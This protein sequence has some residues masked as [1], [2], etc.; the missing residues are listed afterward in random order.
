MIKLNNKLLHILPSTQ[1]SS[2]LLFV[3]DLSKELTEYNHYVIFEKLDPQMDMDT[4]WLLQSVGI[5][6]LFADVLTPE[7]IEK[8]QA[9]GVIIYNLEGHTDLGSV[10]PSIYYSCGVYDEVSKCKMTVAA[11]DYACIY[12]CKGRPLNLNK[13]FVIPP[14]INTRVLRYYNKQDPNFTVGLITSGA[15]DKYPCEFIIELLSKLDKSKDV[16]LGL[17]ILDK[18]KHPGT[19]L[20]IDEYSKTNKL[21]R[22]SHKITAGLYY[23]SHCDVVIYATA[24]NYYEPYSRTVVE[25]M[26]FG[27]PVIC[28]N[29]GCF[30][31][32]FEH[33]NNILLFNMVDEAVEYINK[34]KDKTLRSSIGLNGQL[35]S[36][37][38]DI[39]LH[40]GKMK[41]A[42]RMIGV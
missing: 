42:L 31:T 40:S 23:I 5:N 27:R 8:E 32:L 38:E 13:E 3:I 20:A 22:C 33:N 15:R 17:T 19:Q 1:I 39:S 36:S 35:R 18:Y 37:W 2:D 34:L 4:V 25:A 26:A 14:A 28:E 12:D 16:I 24:N 29:R 41:K 11:S 21:I 10:C 30:P 6:V 9:S 7:V